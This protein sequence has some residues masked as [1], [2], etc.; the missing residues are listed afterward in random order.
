MRVELS[1]E[2]RESLTAEERELV[3]ALE[4]EPEPATDVPDDKRFGD[5][6]YDDVLDEAG[7]PIV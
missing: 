1:I 7:R 3:A 4:A 2:E 6:P 5:L